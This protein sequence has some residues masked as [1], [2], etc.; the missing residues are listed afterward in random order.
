MMKIL[1]N[2]TNGIILVIIGLMHTQFALSSDGFGRQFS[3]FSKSN[4]FYLFH[5]LQ[6]NRLMAGKELFE[7]FAAFWFFYFGV[8]IIPFGLLL[9]V[10]E[11]KYKILP[12]S[13]TISYLLV[14]MM[15]SYMIPESGITFFMLPHAIYMLVSNLYKARRKSIISD[16]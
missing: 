16:K 12:H 7:S 6:E 2:V 8:L 11:R 15:G 4:F 10:I 9:H 1:K 14:V 3:E 13:F 5:D